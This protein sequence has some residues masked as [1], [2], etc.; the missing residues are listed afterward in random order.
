MVTPHRDPQHAQGLLLDTA[1]DA[2]VLMGH[3][4]ALFGSR[5]GVDAEFQQRLSDAR[6]AF[7]Q[8]AAVMDAARD[9][10]QR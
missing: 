4:A 7:T 1:W 2:V 5:V 6:D 9:R 8:T 3:L 10:T